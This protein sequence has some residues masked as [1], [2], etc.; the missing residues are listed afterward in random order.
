[1]LGILSAKWGLRKL[2]QRNLGGHNEFDDHGEDESRDDSRDEEESSHHPSDLS[3]GWV[4][5]LRSVHHGESG[6]V[7]SSKAHG[8]SNNDEEPGGFEENWE[9]TGLWEIVAE[10]EEWDVK[11]TKVDWDPELV[12]L[13]PLLSSSND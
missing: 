4:D 13:W 5:G 2:Q 10:G 6:E 9:G 8:G 1:M 3:P 7:S 11:E 12:R